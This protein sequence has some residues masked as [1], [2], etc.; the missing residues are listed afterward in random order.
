MQSNHCAWVCVC[1]LNICILFSLGLVPPIL[2]CFSVV[3][4]CGF[5]LLWCRV[6]ASIMVESSHCFWISD[7]NLVL[8]LVVTMTYTH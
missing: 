7:R 4:F 5:S 8:R 6:L 3:A 1:V 2:F